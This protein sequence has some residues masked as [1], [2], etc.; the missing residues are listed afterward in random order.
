VLSL[1]LTV[2]LLMSRHSQI[3]LQTVNTFIIADA[4]LKAVGRG[5]MIMN[6]DND[7]QNLQNMLRNLLANI[8]PQYAPTDVDW[9]YSPYRKWSI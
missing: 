2:P 3:R 7:H 5:W 6:G 8:R 1:L 4:C 9:N